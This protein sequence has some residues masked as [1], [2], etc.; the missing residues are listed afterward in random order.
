VRNETPLKT[1]SARAV[2]ERVPI[3]ETTLAL[4]NLGRNKED[5]LLGRG[6]DHLMLEYI[7]KQRNASQ[8]RHL[9]NGHRVLGLDHAANHYRTAIR[10]QDVG[11]R[12]L[13]N[14]RGV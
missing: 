1:K 10:D 11:G 6:V 14:Q 2:G 7:A 5:Q 9:V 4:N 8:Q 3:F 12:L 13:R